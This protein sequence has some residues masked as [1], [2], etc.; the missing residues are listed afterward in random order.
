VLDPSIKLKINSAKNLNHIFNILNNSKT[1]NNEELISLIIK[2][3]KLTT[4]FIKENK[5]LQKMTKLQ[6]ENMLSE[7]LFN[8]R[9]KSNILK[10]TSKT[11]MGG[12]C[13]QTF[14]NDVDRATNS[15]DNQINAAIWSA[16]AAD[17]ATFGADTPIVIVGLIIAMYTIDTDYE[18]NLTY[19]FADYEDCIRSNCSRKKKPLKY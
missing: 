8:L 9:A 4:D 17:A 13:L 2:K 14:N 15:S 3:M 10:S 7:A 16:T 11:A 19:A 6:I 1:V 5:S 12:E 18:N